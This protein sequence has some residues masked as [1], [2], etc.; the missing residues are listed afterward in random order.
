ME[1]GLW[2]PRSAHI[3]QHSCP[4][5]WAKATGYLIQSEVESE[6]EKQ[7][8]HIN[9]YMWNLEKWYKLTYFKGRNR[10]ADEQEI[11][12][13]LVKGDWAKDGHLILSG[14]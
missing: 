8:W 12:L 2:R 11:F 3:Q 13:F 10:D 5:D 7:T 9:T 4:Q 1:D 14:D 6:R